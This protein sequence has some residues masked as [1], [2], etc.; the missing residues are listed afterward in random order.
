MDKDLE[1]IE[2]LARRLG[3]NAPETDVDGLAR[4]ELP[5]GFVFYLKALEDGDYLAFSQLVEL[6]EDAGTEVFRTLLAANLFGAGTGPGHFAL[7]DSSGA[8]VWQARLRGDGGELAKHLL[9]AADLCRQWMDRIEEL[10]AGADADMSDES[11]GREVQNA[12]FIQV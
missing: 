6:P 11:E 9:S 5:D 4:L 3:V 12:D 8:L 7:E 2:S 1:F 10:V